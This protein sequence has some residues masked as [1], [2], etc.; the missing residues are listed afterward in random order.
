MTRRLLSG[1]F[2]SA[3]I[4]FGTVF[5]S[6]FN[7]PGGM[8]GTM[9]GQP[10]QPSQ[11]V[12]VRVGLGRMD[13][14]GSGALIRSDLILTCNH[15]IREYKK[16][17]SLQVSFKDGLVRDAKII[18]KDA[19][20]D[21][22]VLKI[23]PVIIPAVRPASRPAVKGDQIRICGFPHGESYDETHGKMVGYRSANRR[24]GQEFFL[25]NHTST[26]GMSGG[27][28]FNA[29][30]DLTGIL[31]GSLRYSNCVGLDAIKTFLGD[32]D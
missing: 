3:A 1:T 13:E 23:D 26:S 5:V 30:G 31:F 4:I 25:V 29:D 28:A 27:P 20:L 2:L 22:A 8:L 14:L 17:A 9:F 18:K 24:G 19:E 11:V 7:Q 21:L 10:E 6:A 16:G 32:I 12:K 15:V